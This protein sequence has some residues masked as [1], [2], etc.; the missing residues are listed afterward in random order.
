MLGYFFAALVLMS[1]IFAAVS[2]RVPETAQAVMTGAGDA[3]TV[4]IGLAG[5]ICLWSGV[6]RVAEKAGLTSLLSKALSPVLRRL[7][8]SLGKGSEGEQAVCMNV[9]A[10]ILGLGNAATPYGLKA[11]RYMAER[12]P[13]KG[14]ATRDMVVFTV[15][16]TAS[17]QVLPTTVAALRA[18]AGAPA[19]FDILPAVW[20]TSLSS[21]VFGVLLACVTA[22]R[23][24][25]G[26]S[27]AGRRMARTPA[28]TKMGT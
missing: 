2:G 25:D 16:N 17:V 14:A 8:P 18:A 6:M 26:K 20:V 19:P 22:S 13:R 3:V 23:L 24:K 9:S 28:L 21:A 10:N 7:L 4:C 1:I 27:R 11:M 15:L 12:S 5:G